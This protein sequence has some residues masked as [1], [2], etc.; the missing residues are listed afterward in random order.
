VAI[1]DMLTAVLAGGDAQTALDAAELV[2][3]ESLLQ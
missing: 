3:N 1:E 2:C